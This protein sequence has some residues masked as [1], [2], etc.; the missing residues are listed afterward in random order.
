MKLTAIEE[1]HRA[2]LE[3]WRNAMNLVGPGDTMHHFED[4]ARA[5]E[6]LAV[7]GRWI[8]LGSGAGFPGI[9]L[10]ARNPSAEVHLVESRSKRVAFLRAV[11]LEAGVENATIHH[12]R[13]EAI[14]PG[15]DGV[16]SRA[17]KP[18]PLYLADA[19]RLL[20]AGG[21]AVLLSGE[22][23]ASFSG[24]EVRESHTYPVGQQ[25]RVRTLLVQV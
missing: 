14:G 25:S 23:P 18:P 7:T 8:D 22:P 16:I 2:L 15:Y 11:L 12:C 21:T 19:G 6:G 9:A 13:T 10:A 20:K 3:K 4:A 17:Y 1:T 5:V 24:W